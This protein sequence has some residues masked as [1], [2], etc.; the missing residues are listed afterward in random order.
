MVHSKDILPPAW[1]LPSM[2]VFFDG[3]KLWLLLPYRSPVLF[4]QLPLGTGTGQWIGLEMPLELLSSSFLLI[5]AV[6]VS[7]LSQST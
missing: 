2:W 7:S 1:P 3:K 4:K 6:H 5:R